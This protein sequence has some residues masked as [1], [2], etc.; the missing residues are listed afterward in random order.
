MFLPLRFHIFLS[1]SWLRVSQQLHTISQVAVGAVLG[2][3]FSGL[4][5]WSWKAFV[6]EAFNSLLWVR[7]LVI[8]G[9]I[10]FCIGFLLYV[11]RYWFRN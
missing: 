6:L 7:M 1:Q 3:T 8:V 5:Y 10:G 4:W 2:S 11:I 9:A